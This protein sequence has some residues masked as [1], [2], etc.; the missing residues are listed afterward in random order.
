MLV[1]DIVGHALPRKTIKENGDG[2]F[3]SHAKMG[4]MVYPRAQG[5]WLKTAEDYG[6]D[7]LG[8]NSPRFDFSIIDYSVMTG[9]PAFKLGSVGVQELNES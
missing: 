8:E 6:H 4:F 2:G 7:N 1:F 9:S 3:N 5:R